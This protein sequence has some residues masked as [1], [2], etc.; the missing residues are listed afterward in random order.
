L[1]SNMIFSKWGYI[2]SP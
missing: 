1:K 2:D